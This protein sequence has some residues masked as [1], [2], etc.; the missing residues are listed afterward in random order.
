M[1]RLRDVIDSVISYGGVMLV[2]GTI[3]FTG[4]SVA[5]VLLVLSGLLLVQLGVWRVASAVLPSTRT[6]HRLRDAVK[7]H[8]ASVRELYRL[9][10]AKERAS[11]GAVSEN[12][13]GQTDAII[14]AAK[15]D[16][17]EGD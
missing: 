11:F 3:L 1:R 10:N 4:A 16:L 12:L 17:G 5:Q 14:E 2:L 8:L 9:A 6:N 13:R 15:T 7:E